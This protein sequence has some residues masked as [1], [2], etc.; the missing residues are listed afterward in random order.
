MI[1]EAFGK[2]RNQFKSVFFESVW[3]Y[4]ENFGK[5]RKRFKSNFQMFL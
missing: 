5:L 2:H 4:S 1:Y 3:K